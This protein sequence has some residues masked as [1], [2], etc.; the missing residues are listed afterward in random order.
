MNRTRFLG[1]VHVLTLVGILLLPATAWG[2]T[3]TMRTL[4]DGSKVLDFCISVRFNA[5]A[6]QLQ[7]IEDVMT[8]AS[9]LMADVTDGAL[10]F[11][12]VSVFDNSGAGSE[13]E[14]WIHPE[15]GGANAALGFY[16]CRDAHICLFYPNNFDNAELKDPPDEPPPMEKYFYTTVHELSHSLWRILDEYSGLSSDCCTIRPSQ[17]QLC[18]GGQNVCDCERWPG[19]KTA[20][21]C[22]MDNY[23]R[24][25]GNFGSDPGG[26][27]TYTLNE[28]CVA[29][30]HDPDEDTYQNNEWEQSCWETIESHWLRPLELVGAV[31]VDAPPF[32]IAPQFDNLDEGSRYLICLD[33]SGSMDTTDT[34]DGATRLQRALQGSH[35]FINGTRGGDH[36][37]VVAFDTTPELVFALTEIDPNDEAA[38]KNAAKD[39]LPLLTQGCCTAIGLAVEAAQDELTTLPTSCNQPIL[40]LTDGFSN[41]GPSKLDFIASLV[42]DRIP[43]TTLAIG[44]DPKV[45]ELMELSAR[46]GGQHYHVVLDSDLPKL[47]TFMFAEADGSGVI[48][49]LRGHTSQPIPGPIFVDT[50]TDE[51]TFFFSWNNPDTIFQFTLQ[52]PGGNLIDEFTAGADPDVDYFDGISQKVFRIRNAQ[53]GDWNFSFVILAGGHTTYDF[54]GVSSTEDISFTAMPV[55]GISECGKPDSMVHIVATP[56]F[57]G[58]AVVGIVLVDGTVTRPDGT[59]QSITLFDDGTAVSGDSIANDGEYSALITPTLRGAY[60][61]EVKAISVM[62]FTYQ[63]E[64]LFDS[65]G[66]VTTSFAAPLFVRTDITT[67]VLVPAPD[68]GD[69]DGDGMTG[70]LDFLD[71]LGHWGPCTAAFCPGDLDCDGEVGIL[72]FLLLLSNWT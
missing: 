31:P 46:T 27:G 66:D 7:R 43:V 35:L 23:Y 45:E 2:G 72:D 19:D 57:L 51:V 4:G 63:G 69:I 34:G 10:R 70:I 24:R 38:T 44:E 9:A 59:L 17:G 16:G 1:G 11:G 22:L 12:R 54:I 20:T 28:F 36:L 62:G 8:D 21:F 47:S 52:E 6:S 60:T 64:P 13:A 56:R 5:T 33:R 48:Q 41:A 39:A 67:A 71:L 32:I 49:A 61:F 40:L 50:M 30:N 65:V 29:V 25:G 15:E 58:R 53:S 42:N 18:D 3:G 37:G 55:Q 14:I 26:T 68:A